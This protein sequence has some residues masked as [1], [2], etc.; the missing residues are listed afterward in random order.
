[1]HS[2]DSVA[3]MLAHESELDAVDAF[4]MLTP[5][6]S[7]YHRPLFARILRRG[8]GLEAVT[9]IARSE[10]TRSI[11]GTLGVALTRSRLFGT[12]ATS[13]PHFNYGG[14]LAADAGVGTRLLDAAW[15]WAQVRGARHL[16]LRHTTDRPLDLPATYTKETLT[17]AL[18]ADTESLWNSIGAKP[19]NLVRKAQR[20]GL[21]ARTERRGA[22][23][24]FHA[25]FSE[26]MRDLG[27]PALSER[28]FQV[29]LEELGDAAQVHVVRLE[30]RP[31]A[32]AISVSF[33]DRVEV[34][35]AAC[36]SRYKP[37]AA[38]M[39]LYWHLLQHAVRWGARVFDF[40]RSTPGSGPYRFKLQWGAR[41]E[42][43]PW[44]YIATADVPTGDLSLSNPRFALAI[45][46][47]KRLPVGV[48]RILGARL[49]PALP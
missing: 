3:I 10:R 30:D 22:A 17:L 23:G 7:I 39:L 19:R 48:A 45:R 6:A 42:P 20:I 11:V 2:L 33:R 34:P 16:I 5:G 28:F 47:W 25:V 12:Y 36:L 9:F 44:Y 27:T 43:L 41:P 49:A 31:A 24:V 8:A 18:P 35:W 15:T 14:V 29:L 4:V 46:V 38:N 32:A 21:V 26:N 37:L 1:M 40:G 13:L